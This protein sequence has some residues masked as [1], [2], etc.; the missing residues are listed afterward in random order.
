M[1]HIVEKKNPPQCGGLEGVS[2]GE[3]ISFVTDTDPGDHEAATGQGDGADGTTT[4]D[5]LL[6]RIRR[7]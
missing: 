2:P 4:E 3:G 1:S 6:E 7:Y 5:G